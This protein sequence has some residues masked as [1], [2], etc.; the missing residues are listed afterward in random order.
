MLVKLYVGREG[1][2][3]DSEHFKCASCDVLGYSSD[4]WRKLVKNIGGKPTFLGGKVVITNESMGVSQLL[5]ARTRFPSK[6]STMHPIIL[7]QL[8]IILYYELDY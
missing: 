3:H 5:G 8:V 4:H 7:C 6:S 1:S 2:F